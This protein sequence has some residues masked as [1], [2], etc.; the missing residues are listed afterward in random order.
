[1]KT[2]ITILLVTLLLGVCAP[3]L[4]AQNREPVESIAKGTRFIAGSF[5][6]HAWKLDDTSQN[7]QLAIG[8][9]FGYFIKDNLALGGFANFSRNKSRELNPDAHST[10]LGYGLTV[11]LLKSYK[12]ADNL[13]FTLRPQL[14]FSRS[15]RHDSNPAASDFSEFSL[16]LRVS[17]GV[18]FFVTRRFALET[19]LGGLG[20]TYVEQNVNNRTSSVHNFSVSGNFSLFGFSLLYFLR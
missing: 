8:P 20:Y 12:I 5:S 4:F 3:V 17:P 16:G 18:I 9:G 11:F 10:N 19:S 6:F 13:F 7:S 2:I 1:M 15:N 14:S